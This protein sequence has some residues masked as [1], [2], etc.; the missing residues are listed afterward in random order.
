MSIANKLRQILDV[1]EEI[2]NALKDRGSNIDNN[3]ALF[4]YPQ[5]IRDL[6]IGGQPVVSFE[7]VFYDMRTMDISD[8]QSLFRGCKEKDLDLTFMGKEFSGSIEDMFKDC[9]NLETLN[10][11]K[12]TFSDNISGGMFSN[13]PN[14]KKV[15]MNY[16]NY[17]SIVFLLNSLPDHT[18]AAEGDYVFE[19]TNPLSVYNKLVEFLPTIYRGWTISKAEIIDYSMKV[20]KKTNNSTFSIKTNLIDSYISD[21][22]ILTNN[23]I[24]YGDSY[25]EFIE[26]AY[27]NKKYLL[28]NHIKVDITDAEKILD[29][30]DVLNQFCQIEMNINSKKDIIVKDFFNNYDGKTLT[31]LNTYTKNN[32]ASV[33]THNVSNLNSSVSNLKNL[34]ITGQKNSSSKNKDKAIIENSTFDSLISIKFSNIAEITLSNI[35]FPLLYDFQFVFE[36]DQKATL[37]NV[38][39]PEVKNVQ[40]M[41][42]NNTVITELDLSTLQLSEESLMID[43][44]FYG[45]KNLTQVNLSNIKPNEVIWPNDGGN[46]FYNCTKL[47]T[48]IMA[49]CPRNFVEAVLINQ[50]Y[51]PSSGRVYCDMDISDILKTGWTWYH[52]SQL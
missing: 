24:E 46:L 35:N 20:M 11:T 19:M 25:G 48:I 52:S 42:S 45:C 36:N 50:D 10:L 51:L 26:T 29:A 8:H 38:Y 47:R 17:D 3:T 9:V 16:S 37:N 2:K 33:V 6:D 13:V 14:L 22:S 28:P 39:A 1:K 44:M 18:G 21:S 4:D 30:N 12:W 7:D 27:L 32:T 41:F 43:K 15:I 31:S 23:K 40:N 49:N 34:L 5:K